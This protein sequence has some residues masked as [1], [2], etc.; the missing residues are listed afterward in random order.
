MLELNLLF[1]PGVRPECFVA[2]LGA[3]LPSDPEE[4]HEPAVADVGVAFDVEVEVAG[5]GLGQE[6]EAE[7]GLVGEQ[8]V[9]LLPGLALAELE[10]RLASELRQRAA[11]DAR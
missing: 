3:V 2:L 11:R 4:V 6:A 10:R 8:L 5:C 7:P 9:A 1:V